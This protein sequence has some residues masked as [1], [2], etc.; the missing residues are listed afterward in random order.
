MIGAAT[1]P[2][3][4][5]HLDV[6]KRQLLAYAEKHDIPVE[7]KH[8]QGGSPYSMDANLLHISY[9]GRNLDEPSAEAE[10][11]VWRWEVSPEA[12]P[13]ASERCV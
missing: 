4:Y 10:G 1:A 5:T 6:Y 7:M 12:A 11:W 2:V 3:S 9:E 8:K 13:D